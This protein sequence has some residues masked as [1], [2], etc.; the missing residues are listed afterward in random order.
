V[1][2][3][4]MPAPLIESELFG[5]ERGAFTGAHATQIGRFELANR[6][7]IF[8]DE[9]GELPLET[10]VKLLRVLQEQEFEPVGSSR[11][12]RVDVRVIAATNR[13]VQEAVRTG[14]FRPDLFYRLNVF[15]IDVP[16]LR[17]RRA[18]IPQLVMFFLSRFSRKLGKQIS[19]VA[20]ETMQ[21]LSAY[22]WPGNVRELQNVIERAV[23]LC[24]ERVLEIDPDLL[25]LQAATSRASE[26][27]VPLG[28]AKAPPANELAEVRAAVPDDIAPLEEIE[29]RH[30]VAAL[31]STAGVIHGP[32]GAAR[33]LK[34]NPTTLRSR[35]EKLG[36]TLKR[37]PHET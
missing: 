11:T 16:P 14:R 12:I 18:D 3:A 5:R 31:E 9:I 27:L 17:E 24:E 20:P 34:L 29:R 2:C 28:S 35:M 1:N 25:P 22:E 36:I 37:T 19:A 15:P 8:L 30:I 32:K 26:P 4:A 21:H 13:D 23:V 33:I 6:G 7:T 10:Q